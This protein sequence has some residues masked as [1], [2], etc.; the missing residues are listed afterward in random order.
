MAV[1]TG[2]VEALIRA[3]AVLGLIEFFLRERRQQQPQSFE[4]KRRQKSH[5]QRI[6]V[7][8]GQ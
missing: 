3:F 6:V 5:H 2:D 8:D 1:E 4:L 7:L